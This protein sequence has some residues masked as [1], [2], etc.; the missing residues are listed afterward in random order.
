MPIKKQEF[1][2]GAALYL[3]ARA[4]RIA[5]IS[6]DPPFFVLNKR[7][8]VLLKICTKNRSPWGFT[9]TTL[10]QERLQERAPKYCSKIGL[11]CG[12]DGV[13]AVDYDD[14]LEIARHRKASVHIACYRQHGEYYEVSG[15]D[16]TLK[17][18]ISP[19]SWQKIFDT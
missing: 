7:Y 15:P 9:F 3:L 10:E 1:Y 8:L 4:G 12:A 11:V 18:K 16:G 13:A 6:L 19:S 2:E 14:Y 17:N 5:G